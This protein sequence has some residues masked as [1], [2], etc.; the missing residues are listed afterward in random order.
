[1]ADEPRVQEL[2]AEMLDSESTPEEVC[3]SCPELL[4]LVQERWR[5]MC[6]ARADLDAMFPLFGAGTVLPLHEGARL[7]EIAGYRVEALLGQGGMGVVF[8][9]RHLSLNRV[10][11]LKM[12]LAGAY[13]G[14]HERERFQ[15]EAEAVAGLKHPSIVQ[16][17]DVGDSDGRPY[18][19]MEYVDGGSLA[20][21]LA[22][23]PQAPREAAE[24]LAT[25]ASGVHAAHQGGIVH[26]DLKP[27]NVLLTSDGT[28]KVSDFGLARRVDN[29]AG[30]TRTGTAL[31]T[32]SYMAPEQAAGKRFAVEP[33][34]DIYALGAI[35]YE[36]L[37]GRPP[38]RAETAAE[39]IQQVLSLEPVPPSR[40]NP[41]VPR[42]LEIICLKCLHKE[43]GF[44]YADA[45][46]LGEDLGRFLR[47]EAIKARPEG[48]LERLTRRIRRRPAL[49]AMVAIGTLLAIGV[50]GSGMW[51]L[52]DRAETTRRMAAEQAAAER[53]ADAHLRDMAKSMQTDSWPEASVALDRAKAWLGTLGSDELKSRVDQGGR[54][55]VL[56]AR[57]DAIRLRVGDSLD[58]RRADEEYEIA[59][60]E[61]KLG[62]IGDPPEV[63][64][65]RV[66]ASNIRNALLAA[67]DYWSLCT[68]SPQRKRWVSDVTEHADGD[69]TGWRA[70]LRDPAIWD[71]EAALFKLIQ[72]APHPEQ[73]VTSLLAA[74]FGVGMSIRTR[75]KF[76]MRLHEAHPRDFWMN[77]RLANILTVDGKHAD[78][79]GY[80]QAAAA[81]RS[82]AAPAH[83]ALG[84][85]L[86]HLQRFDEAR[87]RIRESV[88]LDPTGAGARV[89]YAYV[90]LD[91]GRNVEAIE[92]AQ[93]AVG[94]GGDKI[95]RAHS[96]LG[97]CLATSNRMAEAVDQYRK[98]VAMDPK[99][100]R[101]QSEF[102]A[103][104]FRLGR[105]DESLAAWGGIIDDVP[106]KH[107]DWYGYAELCLFLGR[108]EEY[109]RA[110]RSLLAKFG[111]VTDLQIAERT[112]RACLL[113]PLEGDELA[114]TVA[115]AD[116]PAAAAAAD[117]GKHVAVLWAFHFVK[118][119]AEYR[120]GYYERAISTMNG[121]AAI[122]LVPAPRL[123]I[124]MAQHKSGRVG[125]AR[126]TLAAAI[127][128][129]DWRPERVRNQDDWIIHVLRREAE[130]MILP[131]L[132]ALLEGKRLPRDNDERL[133]MLGAYE[134]AN[135]FRETARL[136]ADALAA[137]PA[138]VRNLV[139]VHRFNAARYAALAGCSKG[140]NIA[141]LGEP[142]RKQMR[143]QS[144]RWLREELAA[145][146]TA[147][148]SDPTGSRDRVRLVLN[149]CRQTPDLAGLREPNEVEKLTPDE[150]KDCAAL[151]DEFG[152]VIERTNKSK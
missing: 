60:R 56:A 44:R 106:P 28:P 55:L 77:M 15:R 150:R 120:Q 73:S 146:K 119:L 43:P 91:T 114:Q 151:W 140:A 25:L 7:P 37:T 96:V 116:R 13:A 40:L 84:V 115:L 41:K 32:P 137:E 90:L 61:A 65:T 122:A 63:V 128:A 103:L 98:A 70:R 134:F 135:R 12:V 139:S 30:L 27:S 57:L 78:A 29:D 131:D 8:R 129:H 2:L 75:L 144:R 17:Y 47:G 112:S 50:I 124:A 74:E 6:Q 69:K 4:P 20:R 105:L 5:Q 149:R 16:I 148:D 31:G 127:A 83:L 89:C 142:E 102:R 36:L 11:A 99:D 42:D 45:A 79:I 138:L 100:R 19:T 147:L 39:T 22:G 121:D 52:S 111:A 80:Y 92:E 117:P 24:L 85:A 67:L 125:E 23:T 58:H 9:A 35:L 3:R 93:A 133:T 72:D 86:A 66:R 68:Q 48:R 88:R 76:L 143:E 33:T 82:G 64:A 136:Y 59:F 38:F 109:L 145:C 34:V 113:R 18:F 62:Q 81:I 97:K 26:R 1:M 118:G 21:K 71:D 95:G 101:T 46:S 110:R 108:E 130:S 53:A 54:D 14:Q 51:L 132:P 10:V 94:L 107:D 152:V 123:V 141:T 104:L 49:S 126:K 87:V